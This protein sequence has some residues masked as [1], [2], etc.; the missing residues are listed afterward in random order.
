MVRFVTSQSIGKGL[1]RPEFEHDA[2]GIGALAHLK[3]KRSH[4]MIDDALSVLVNLEHRGGVGLEKN[5]GDGAGILFQVPHRFFRKEAQKCGHLLPSEGDYGVAMLFLPEDQEGIDCAIRVFEEGCARNGVP[6]LFWRDVP[7]DPHDLGETARSCMPTIKQAFLAR[8]DDVLPGEPFERRLY[9]C[10]RTIEKAAAAEPGLID[11]IFY[12]CSMS[13]R[14]VVYKGMLVATQMRRFFS[15]LG[16]ASTETA[17]ALVHSR[18]STNTTPSWER[19]HPNRFI[20]HNGEINTLRCNVNWTRAREA[21]LYYPV[22]GKDLECVLPILN[23]EGSDS[24]MLDNVLEFVAMNG[25]S[26][27][28]AV[29]MVL[30]EPWDNND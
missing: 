3:G 2:C 26:L 15:D 7:V 10:R 11:R 9:V 4:Q 22:M 1:Y 29:S 20:V 8:P 30:P 24:A 19:A 16:D 6:L 28:R 17:I 5:T 25:R 12:V 13:S 27:A 14:T 21:G 23:G 18:Y